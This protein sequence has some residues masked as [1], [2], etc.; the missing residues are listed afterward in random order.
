MILKDYN[1]RPD[2]DPRSED[3]C[4]EV[5]SRL[6]NAFR[7]NEDVLV[8]NDVP[9]AIEHRTVNVD[10]VVLH[11]YGITLI[12][13][14]TLYGKIEVNYRHEWSRALKGRDLP[15]ENPIE[16]FKY[17]SRHLRNKLVKHTAQVLSKANGIQKTFD[18]LPIDVVFVQAPKSNI[19]GSV[20]Y[21]FC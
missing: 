13:S 20:E 11:S 5:A 12:N 4:A 17:V 6:R 1:H 9:I 7:T 18:V 15:M 19:Q 10:Q 14:R 2:A 21:D 8:L 3:N 16:L